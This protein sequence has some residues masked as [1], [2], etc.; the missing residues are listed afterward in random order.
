VNTTKKSQRAAGFVFFSLLAAVI[1]GLAL[2]FAYA[3][4][5]DTAVPLLIGC[6]LVAFLLVIASA[7][8]TVRHRRSRELTE[9][10][11]VPPKGLLHALDL[12][13]WLM[14]FVGITVIAISTGALTGVR[15]LAGDTGPVLG[16]TAA[17]VVPAT[18]PATLDPVPPTTEVAPT[19]SE[20]PEA[21]PEPDPSDVGEDGATVEPSG[22]GPGTPAPG[23]T[24]YLDSEDVIDG[25]YSAKAVSLSAARYSRGIS[26]YCDTATNTILQWNV[27]GSSRF[28]AT[29]GIDDNTDN[30]FGI[31]AEFSFY[32]QDGRKLRAKPVEVSVGHPAK[33]TLDLT[34]VVSLRMTCA[35]R[36]GKTD[37][38][39]DTYAV[40]GDPII[41]HQ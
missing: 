32:D 30:T 9:R 25:S 4:T 11:N 17:P 15:I 29:A 37:V 19:P 13:Q 22:D 3:G 35:G 8:I 28:S 41:V 14:L 39:K 10:H 24:K 12:R 38:Q 18:A 20:T 33:V 23:S 5:V 6:V 21:T 2:Y 40:L 26:F 31:V 36:D 34:G 7:R 1:A 27:A 16:A